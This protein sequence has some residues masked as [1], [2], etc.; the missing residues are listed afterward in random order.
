MST[1][2]WTVGSSS[3]SETLVDADK[4]YPA[5]WNELRVAVNA[6][7]AILDPDTNLLSSG[8]LTSCTGLPISTGISGLAANVAT[9]LAT[10]SSANLLAAVTDETGT[11]AAVFGTAPTITTPTIVNLRGN[12]GWGDANETWTYAS[13]STFTITGDVTAKYPKGTRLKW[14]QTTI[15]Y[16]VV[17]ASSYGAPNTTITIAV[18]TDY[19]IADAAITLNYYSYQSCPQGYPG[20]FDITS[21]VWTVATYDDGAGG[22]P[23]NSECRMSIVGNQCTIHYRGNGTKGATGSVYITMASN[24]FITPAN[25]TNL[26]IIGFVYL[27]SATHILATLTQNFIIYSEVAIV[28]NQVLT[29]V[30]F[31]AT[32]EI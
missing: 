20:W 15:K 1:T 27:G 28:D 9:F 19:T 31:T 12:D 26:T 24:S 4:V 18:N 3:A 32:Y 25:S 16:G 2:T 22:Q 21:P 5:H 29:S 23:T 8:V 6:L 14:T 10:P 7:E 30:S 17:V 11:G 13:A